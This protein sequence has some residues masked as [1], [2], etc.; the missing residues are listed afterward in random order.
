MN[1][2]DVKELTTKNG[3]AIFQMLMNEKEI[4]GLIKFFMNIDFIH[5][6]FKINSQICEMTLA[7]V[8]L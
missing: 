5:I 3:H 8:R 7:C 2:P 1:L 6:Y 4:V